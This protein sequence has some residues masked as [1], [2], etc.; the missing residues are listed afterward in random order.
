MSSSLY[1]QGLP[2]KIRGKLAALSTHV[3]GHTMS[4]LNPLQFQRHAK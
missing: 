3:S 2:D 4:Y 1:L